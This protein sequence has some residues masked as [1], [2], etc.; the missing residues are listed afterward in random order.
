MLIFNM[1]IGGNNNAV[2]ICMLNYDVALPFTMHTYLT[3]MTLQKKF[4]VIKF[5]PYIVLFR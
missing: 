1:L 4:N 2:L 5:F 3:L